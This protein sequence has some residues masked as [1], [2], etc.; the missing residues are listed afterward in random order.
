[1]RIVVLSII[2]VFMSC[3]SSK[4]T[5]KQSISKEFDQKNI[6][7]Y[8]DKAIKT[9][10]KIKRNSQVDES[11]VNQTGP[12]DNSYNLR[13]FQN[14]IINLRKDDNFILIK[15]DSIYLRLYKN[16]SERFLFKGNFILEKENFNSKDN[17]FSNKYT[18]KGAKTDYDLLI[19]YYPN[20]SVDLKLNSKM[21]YKGTWSNYKK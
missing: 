12:I 17:S 3:S 10:L 9:G 21:L 4:S 2:V 7:S 14:N 19:N 13:S 20:N 6:I 16:E 15:K 11:I 8:F 1:M 5:S 18:L